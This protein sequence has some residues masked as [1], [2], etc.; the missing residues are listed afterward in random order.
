MEIIEKVK[1]C[2]IK[3]I[4]KDVRNIVKHYKKSFGQND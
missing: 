2:L 3:I 4:Q 1:Y